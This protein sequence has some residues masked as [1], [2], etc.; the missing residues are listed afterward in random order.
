VLLD[1]RDGEVRM[2]KTGTSDLDYDLA[3]CRVRLRH[4]LKLRLRLHLE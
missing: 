2:A 3:G 1:I 4:F